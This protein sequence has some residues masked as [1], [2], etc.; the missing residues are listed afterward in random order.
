MS[1]TPVVLILVGL[2]TVGASCSSPAEPPEAESRSG[3]EGTILFI[4]VIGQEDTQAFFTADADGSHERQ[5]TEPGDYCCLLRMSPDRT[6]ILTI[7]GGAPPTPITGGVL[8]VDGS[9]FELLKTTDPT[10]NLVPQD[11]SPNGERIAFEGWDDSDPSRTGVYT[12]RASDLGDLVRVTD[13][14][15]LP[16][17]IPLDYSPDGTQ[18]VFY[19]A[20]R[21]EPNFPIDIGGSLWVVNVDGSNAH[22]LKTPG[23]APGWWARWSPDGTKI[24]FA[25]ERL[26]PTGALWTV[27][28]DGSGLTKVFEDEEGRFATGPTWS[29][30]G[31]QILFTLNRTKDSFVHEPNAFYVIQ[32][33]G[34]DLTQVIGGADFKGSPEWW[35]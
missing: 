15:R 23:T 18:L 24:L 32:A 22:R 2:L 34:S 14:P 17:D 31:T 20:A 12:A 19:R 33:D 13:T 25:T 27:R 4:R 35:G 21:A 9:G 5:L 7:P 30:D 29:P 8:S 3:P 11:W 1:R 28:P 16:H 10:L 26:Q 6:G